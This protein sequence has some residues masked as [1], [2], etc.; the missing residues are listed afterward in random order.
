MEYDIKVKIILSIFNFR[1]FI[2]IFNKQTE[3]FINNKIS[4]KWYNQIKTHWLVLDETDK[5]MGPTGL[6]LY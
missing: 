6:K 4:D 5:P 2:N 1:L 3:W